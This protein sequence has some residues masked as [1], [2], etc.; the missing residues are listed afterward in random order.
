MLVIYFTHNVSSIWLCSVVCFR[1]RE[2][3]LT[4]MNSWEEKY[5]N[6]EWLPGTYTDSR[7]VAPSRSC[8]SLVFNR[9]KKFVT[10]GLLRV[11]FPPFSLFL[12]SYHRLYILLPLSSSVILSRV[13]CGCTPISWP[14]S[15]IIHSHLYIPKE[16]RGWSSR[17][18]HRFM[19]KKRHP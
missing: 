6:K 2:C 10:R 16:L 11:S 15:E 9:S 3:S 19:N 17:L 7:V 13:Y 12:S 18:Y 14:D 4:F 1:V 8:V 5:N